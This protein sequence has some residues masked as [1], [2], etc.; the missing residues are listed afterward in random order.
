MPLND[1]YNK[2]L[3]QFAR[4][5]RKNSTLAEIVLWNEV[6][7]NRKLGYRFLRQRPI[8]DYIGDFYCKDLKLFIELDGS[9]HFE[10]S[11]KIKDRMKQYKIESGGYSLLRFKDEQVVGELDLV[12]AKIESWIKGY[13][14]EHPEVLRFKVRK[15]IK[16]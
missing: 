7:K 12:K 8:L 13:E 9:T 2:N 10:K 15:K 5:L 14:K 16:Q 6:L 4:E 1:Y 11:V 3:K